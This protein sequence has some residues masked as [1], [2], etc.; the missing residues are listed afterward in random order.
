MRH[1]H[2][3]AQ[4]VNVAPLLLS[5]A[6]QPEL[7]NSHDVRTKSPGTPHS[8]VDD[9]LV[10]FND[11]RDWERAKGN[12]GE[13]LA[14]GLKIVDEH[15]SVWFPAA[16]QLPA[17]RP[18]IFALMAAVQGE[19]LGRVIIT[20][21]AP[22]KRIAPHC[23]GGDHAEYYDRYQICLQNSPGSLFRVEGEVVTFQ[24][25][26]TWWFNNGLE[27]EVVNNSKEDR[28]VLI[29]D[30]RAENYNRSQSL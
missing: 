1:F 9:I 6:R 29:V 11:L 7:W 25:G 5:L 2:R 19:R 14:A 28:I 23:D 3:L 8:Q 24:P 10:R 4:G 16:Y 15:E 17:V 30:I 21:L 26:E 20:R 13:A 22:G 27:H 18:M 12:S